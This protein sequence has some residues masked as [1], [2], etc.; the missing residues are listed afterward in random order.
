M[1]GD[2]WLGGR[3]DQQVWAHCMGAQAAYELACSARAHLAVRHILRRC[4]KY[5]Q[6]LLSLR[7]LLR[8]LQSCAGRGGSDG[9]G[10]GSLVSLT[11]LEAV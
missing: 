7:P 5:A 3:R 1:G 10:A 11:V 4:A 9:L 2:D 8:H 6:H